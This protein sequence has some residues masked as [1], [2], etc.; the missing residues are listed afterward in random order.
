MKL[1]RLIL[2][3]IVWS[4]HSNAS[5]TNDDSRFG[6]MN[7]SFDTIT[8][9]IPACL[10]V[11]QFSGIHQSSASLDLDSSGKWIPVGT[12]VSEGKLLQ[13]EWSTKGV[14]PRPSKYKV[15][16]RVDP[17]FEK[18]QVFIQKYD[19]NQDKYISDFHHYKDGVLL[20]YQAVPEMTFQDRVKDYADY[21]KFKERLKI[22]VKK[23][24]VINITLDSTGSYFG[25]KSEMNAELGSLDSLVV[26]YTQSS[27]PD[28]RIIY[29]NAQQFCADG[30]KTT[31]AVEYAENC[32]TPGLYWDLGTNTKTMQ[33]RINNSA[34]YINKTNL[35]S[36]AESSN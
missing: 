16:Y 4:V 1:V 18:P 23:D 30:I 31:R 11:P 25:S 12:N 15:L 10:E 2:V 21:F 3:L 17:R 32:G 27:I 29:S 35:V 13:I 6:W 19:Y 28:N 34:F 36:C 7:A 26:A 9:I 20:R 24:D 22:P 5:A 8:S 14:L 33:G